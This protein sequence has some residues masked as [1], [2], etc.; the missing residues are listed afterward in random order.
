MQVIS[1]KKNDKLANKRANT[2][3]AEE[4]VKPNVKSGRTIGKSRT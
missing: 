2:I 3:Y 4:E 1:I